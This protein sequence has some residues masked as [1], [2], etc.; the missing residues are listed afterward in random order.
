MLSVFFLCV[1][2]FQMGVNVH[3][4]TFLEGGKCPLPYM[5]E[6]ANVLTCSF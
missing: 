1:C 3:P 2:F 4:Y 5:N 6:G